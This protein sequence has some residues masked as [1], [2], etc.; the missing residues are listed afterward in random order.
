MTCFKMNH[1]ERQSY[2]YIFAITHFQLSNCFKPDHSTQWNVKRMLKS[3][4]L[5]ALIWRFCL[6]SALMIEVVGEFK[7]KDTFFTDWKHIEHYP[8]IYQKEFSRRY[9][10]IFKQIYDE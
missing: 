4:F 6:L 1:A 5:I 9:K 10:Y 3:H 8:R 2:I 7:F